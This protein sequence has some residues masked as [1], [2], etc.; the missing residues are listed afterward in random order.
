MALSQY[1]GL[2]TCV[3]VISTGQVL[4]KF[5]AQYINGQAHLPL[6]MALITNIYLWIALTIQFA[7]AMLWM[8]LL[9]TIPLNQAYPFIALCF[10]IVPLLSLVFLREEL[11][12]SYWLGV[13]LIVAGIVVIKW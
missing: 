9:R 12:L 10:V 3:M 8:W 4:F 1:I 7:S 6:W 11:N 13:L 2:L 5:A